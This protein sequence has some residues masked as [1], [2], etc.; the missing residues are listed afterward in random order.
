[1]DPDPLTLQGTI[2]IISK[3]LGDNKADIIRENSIFSRGPALQSALN[4]RNEKDLI[5]F[6]DIGTLIHLKRDI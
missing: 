3:Q 6:C 1:M 5:F 2:D 4:S